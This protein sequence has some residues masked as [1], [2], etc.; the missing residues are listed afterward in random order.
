MT[1]EEREQ[2]LLEQRQEEAQKELD[3]AL[4]K[5]FRKP[6]QHLTLDDKRFLQA[7]RSYLNKEMTEK[8]EDVLKEKL[9]GRDGKIA[10]E[11]EKEIEVMT[12]K[13]LEAMAETEG[14]TKD[15]IKKA[16][17]N[18]DLQAAIKQKQEE[19]EKGE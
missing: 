19:K 12:R 5:I 18:A 3:E 10:A 17:T 8:Y 7:R 16:R 11:D 9:P 15:E 14:L 4:K 6:V 2:Q 1:P 13:E